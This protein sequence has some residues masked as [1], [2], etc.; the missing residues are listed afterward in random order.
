MPAKKKAAKKAAKKKK[1]YYATRLSA[2]FSFR[3]IAASGSI[4]EA[5]P[6]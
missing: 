2:S 3:S 1:K 4:R 5:F 6:L